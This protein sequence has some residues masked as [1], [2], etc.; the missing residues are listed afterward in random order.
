MKKIFFLFFIFCICEFGYTQ[1]SR[2]IA[3]HNSCDSALT[4]LDIWLIRETGATKQ[5]TNFSYLSKLIINNPHTLGEFKIGVAKKNSTS[6]NDTLIS[7]GPYSIAVGESKV[8]FVQGCLVCSGY[9]FRN[10]LQLKVENFVLPSRKVS[11]DSALVSYS[12][13]GEDFYSSILRLPNGQEQL[14]IENNLGLSIANYQNLYLR[15]LLITPTG[16]IASNEI[17]VLQIGDEQ[18]CG[19]FT[20]IFN[21]YPDNIF[22]FANKQDLLKGKAIL[23]F[24]TGMKKGGSNDFPYIPKL[25]IVGIDANGNY[26]TLEEKKNVDMQFFNNLV[27]YPAVD[28][29]A[30]NSA[31]QTK[32]IASNVPYKKGTPLRNIDFRSDDAQFTIGVAPSGSS[33]FSNCFFTKTVG[34]FVQ[35]PYFVMITGVRN[36]ANFQGPN[37]NPVDFV[38][39]TMRRK[40]VENGVLINSQH[41]CTDCSDQIRLREKNGN[42][43]LTTNYI[44]VITAAASYNFYLPISRKFRF[45][46]GLYSLAFHEAYLPLEKW[47]DSVFEA[48]YTG[49]KTPQFPSGLDD[50]P[51]FEVVFITPSGTHYTSNLLTLTANITQLQLAKFSIFPTIV[52][53]AITIQ[54][55][56]S[57]LNNSLAFSIHDLSGKIVKQGETKNKTLDVS[58]LKSGVYMIQVAV[59]D[60]NLGVVKFI[61]K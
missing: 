30:K 39:S 21:F 10:I 12:H 27:E 31:G 17:P 42:E 37:N 56:N 4:E 15:R 24:S 25:G 50:G 6:V 36:R 47:R 58:N 32:K 43:F 52:E 20:N 18:P 38:F 19:F 49:F 11:A 22:D 40:G 7:F 23:F 41:T 59:K 1:T 8:G 29:W 44:N 16:E 26:I 54:S 45:S 13:G 53:N 14:N 51:G 46:E 2:F 35:F 33:N 55:N 48:V 57:N 61:K 3:I 60:V 9:D 28:F 5:Q 34:Y